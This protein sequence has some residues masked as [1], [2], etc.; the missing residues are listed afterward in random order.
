MSTDNWDEECVEFD[1]YLSNA[2]DAHHAPT[3]VKIA[4][5][6]SLLA[7]MS[8][9]LGLNQFQTINCFVMTVKHVFMENHDE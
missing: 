5:L 7:D 4:V 1:I 2:L 8:K 3:E 9:E 6:A